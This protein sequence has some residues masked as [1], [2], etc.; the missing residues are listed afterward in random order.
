MNFADFVIP[1]ERLPS[2]A[3]PKKNYSRKVSKTLQ[4]SM[5]WF[6]K[7]PIPG[8]WIAKAASLPGHSLHVALAIC[9]VQG[10][11]GKSSVILTRK[12]FDRFSTK[13]NSTCRALDA[14]SEKKYKRC[15]GS[16]SSTDEIHH[17]ARNLNV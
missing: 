4:T 11:T 8:T 13:K 9:Y 17:A 1:E 15:C 7:G 10:C 14:R 12:E 6:I 2:P 5:E 3:R 16:K